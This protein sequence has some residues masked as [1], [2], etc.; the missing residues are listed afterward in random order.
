MN[1]NQ[2]TFAF[3][4]RAALLAMLL[5]VAPA[6]FADPPGYLFKDI[7]PNTQAVVSIPQQPQHATAANTALSTAQAHRVCAILG[8]D[9]SADAPCVANLERLSAQSDM[10]QSR[11][12]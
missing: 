3:L 1:T 5:L 2:Q 9:A 7:E 4:G 11:S 10:A 8:V 12:E 6:A